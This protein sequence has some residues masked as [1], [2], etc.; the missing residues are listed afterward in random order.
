MQSKISILALALAIVALAVA[1]FTNAPELA[2]PS[3]SDGRLRD[4]QGQVARLSRAVEE[5]SSRLPGRRGGDPSSMDSASRSMDAFPGISGELGAGPST[6]SEER[7]KAMVDD[8]VSKKARE[9]VDEL[10]IKENKKPSIDVFASMLELTQDQR[11]ATE[12]E[13]LRGQRE[14][15][16]ILETPTQDGGNLMDELI[17]VVTRNIVWPGK[18]HGWGKWIARVTT[19]KVP[20]TNETY[21]A[22]IEAVKASVRDSFRRTFSKEQYAEY[23]AWG[24][25][26]IEVKGIAGSPAEALERRV[27]DRIKQLGEQF[28][29]GP[30]K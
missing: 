30:P 15:Y 1:A 28:P 27:R 14:A 24:V 21:G 18:D 29:E 25:D 6:H 12:Q 2:A 22:R 13:V 10:K 5:L 7:L 19:L 3:R 16:R 23:E 20:G 4:L 17:E 26:P 9:V 11:Y 8:A